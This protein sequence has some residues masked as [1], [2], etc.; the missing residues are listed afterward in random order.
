M[1]KFYKLEKDDDIHFVINEKGY[2][3]E[4]WELKQ[5]IDKAIEY[6]E[7][8]LKEGRSKENQWLMGCYDTC[9]ELLDI[10]KGSDKK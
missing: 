1:D 3:K 5:R 2:G 7:K 6:C 4:N 10:L 8:D 9:K